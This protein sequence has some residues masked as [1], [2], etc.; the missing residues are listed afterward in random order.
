MESTASAERQRDIARLWQRLAQKGPV[1]RGRLQRELQWSA[2][3]LAEILQAAA[4]DKLL[5]IGAEKALTRGEL[6]KEAARGFRRCVSVKQTEELIPGLAREGALTKAVAVAGRRTL[7][8]RAGTFKPLLRALLDRVKDLGF[9]RDPSH[10]T[11]LAAVE[12]APAPPAP[13]LPARIL[14]SLREFEEAPG[15]PVTVRRLRAALP[16]I[17]KTDF[18]RAVLSLADEQQVY[19]IRHDHGWALPEAER[20]QLVYDGGEKLYVGVQLRH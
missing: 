15:V 19:L 13:D 8:Y 18:D 16:G 3:R 14:Q 5:E 1:S 9:D 7:F 20:D 12:G 2:A 6:A 11:L 4:R 17:P 10:Q